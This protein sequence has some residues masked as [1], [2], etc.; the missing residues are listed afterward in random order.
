LAARPG[1]HGTIET[2]G[3]WWRVRFRVDVPGQYHQKQVAVRI[4]P[5]EGVGALSKTE[6][7]RRALQLMAEHGANTDKAFRE[8]EAGTLGGTFREQ[9][10]RWLIQVQTRKRKPVKAKTISNW[11]SH[12]AWINARIGDMPLRDV[13][14]LTA[15]NLIAEMATAPSRRG[16]RFS[17][18]T[19]HNYLQVIKSVVA[20]VVNDQGEPVFTRKW[21]H[22]FIDLPIISHQ[23][24]PSLTSD[25]VAHLISN[26]E[27]QYRILFALLAGT[28]LRVGEALA[29]EV[30][31]LNAGNALTVNKSI[32]EALVS[33]PKTPSGFREVD[34]PEEL[35]GLLR[36]HIGVRKTGH[37]FQT[38]SGTPLS[39]RNVL[40]RQLHPALKAIGRET[41]GFHA[42]RRYRVTHLRRQRIP[43]DL[44]RFWLGHAD[45][46]VTDGYCKLK[47]DVEY[48]KT[49]AQSAGIGFTLPEPTAV[50]LPFATPCDPILLGTLTVNA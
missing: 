50:V 18:K 27:G 49:M 33:S 36:V 1:Q 21:N 48:R 44:I 6:R 26:T 40:G 19:Q 4:C 30:G 17:A 46:S 35:A 7:S 43:E 37:I 32:W 22:E 23:R 2:K 28:G 5:R 45:R 31:D 38:G 14:N 20:S 3:R 16:G 41:F 8:W 34:L 10:E 24:T 11:R 47:D 25:E 39:Q 29:L 13:N 9:S 42:F 12:L 15:R